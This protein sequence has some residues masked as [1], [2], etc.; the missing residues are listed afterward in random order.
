M[1]S[2]SRALRFF[3]EGLFQATRQGFEA[4]NAALKLRAE[5]S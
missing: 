3:G 5:T 2:G 4:M 1:P